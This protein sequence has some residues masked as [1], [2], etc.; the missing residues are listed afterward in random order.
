ME[1]QMKRAKC[2]KTLELLEKAAPVAQK[3]QEC[4]SL[5][6]EIVRLKTSIKS[7]D[8]MHALHEKELYSIQTEQKEAKEMAD[9]ALKTANRFQR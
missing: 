8:S 3:E 2:R 1:R 7:A 5:S 9:S 4:L 6:D